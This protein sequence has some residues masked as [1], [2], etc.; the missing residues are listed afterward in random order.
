MKTSPWIV[1]DGYCAM[2][3]IA[4]SDPSLTANRVAFIEKTPRIRVAPFSEKED[5]KNWESGPSGS[6]GGDPEKDETYG[7]DPYS[8]KWCDERLIAMGFELG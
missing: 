7:F 2:R 6:G 8:R 4:G 5:F 1:K 3:V